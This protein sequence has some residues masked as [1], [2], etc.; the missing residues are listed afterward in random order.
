MYEHIFTA[1]CYNIRKQLVKMRSYTHTHTHVCQA[2]EEENLVLA[3]LFN[4]TTMWN[5]GGRKKKRI[6]IPLKK[7]LEKR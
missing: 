6:W 7:Q 4:N 5:K 1:Y 3:S 2:M